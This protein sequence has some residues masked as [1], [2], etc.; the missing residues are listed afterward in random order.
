MSISHVSEERRQKEHEE[1][2]SRRLGIDQENDEEEEEEEEDRSEDAIDDYDEFD[3]ECMERIVAGF[4]SIENANS[5]S[6]MS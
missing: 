3:G 5:L 6:A 1:R 4:I 2:A